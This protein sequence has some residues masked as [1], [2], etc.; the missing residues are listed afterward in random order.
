MR[1]HHKF[2][3]RLRSLFRKN[4]ADLDLD[5]EVQFHL[6]QQTDEYISQGMS[7]E[8]ARY[9]ALRSLGGMQQ[10]KEEC[11]EARNVNFVSNFGQD[12]RFGFR[13]L[14]RNPGFAVLTILCLTIG[15]GATAAVFSWIEGILF[16][17]FPAVAHQERM[18]AITGT[19]TGGYDKGSSGVTRTD[20]SWL[21]FLDYRR[22]C[23]LMDWFIVDKI[24]GTTLNIGDRA[25]R[26]SGEVVS[27]NYFDALGVRPILGRA[28]QPE[29]D[30][31]RNGHPVVVISYWLWKERFHGDPE[32]IGKKQLLNGV[33]HTIVGVAPEGFYG[34]FVGY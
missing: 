16:R 32:I 17:P 2:A 7:R 18:V 20:V 3:L 8:E 25:E 28:F 13:I 4:Q 23:T 5:D 33:P 12:L 19:Q 30:W 15:I 26:A 10:M 29:E 27:S 14:R 1:W 9:A 24:T 22:N 31:G 34:T 11:R 21:D 6:Q